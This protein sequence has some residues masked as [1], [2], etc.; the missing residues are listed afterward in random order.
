MK[1][2]SLPGRRLIHAARGLIEAIPDWLATK[3]RALPKEAVRRSLGFIFCGIEA[4]PGHLIRDEQD[5]LFCAD[6]GARVA[7]WRVKP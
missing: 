4:V 1:I 3:A 6:R 5:F 2:V 7:A